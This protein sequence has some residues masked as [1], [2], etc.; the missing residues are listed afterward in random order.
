[1]PQYKCFCA[2]FRS[3]KLENV[4]CTVIARGPHQLDVLLAPNYRQIIRDFVPV[5]LLL[6]F[7]NLNLS[8]VL[9]RSLFVVRTPVVFCQRSARLGSQNEIEI[10]S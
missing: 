8:S 6:L 5:T 2:T 9:D 7:S 3:G 10:F 4:L 1:M